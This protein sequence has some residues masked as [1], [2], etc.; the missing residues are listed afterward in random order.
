M[1]YIL[2]QIITD[3]YRLLLFILDYYTLIQFITVY[4]CLL[5]IITYYYR[6]LEFTQSFISRYHLRVISYIVYSVIIRI[7]FHIKRRQM[8][9]FRNTPPRMIVIAIHIEFIPSNYI[10]IYIYIYIYYSKT[11]SMES[12]WR[13][14]GTAMLV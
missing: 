14:F 13:R 3:Y 5:Q 4:Y 12:C 7:T 8:N 6:F 10:Y 9:T 11:S 1:Y 2:L